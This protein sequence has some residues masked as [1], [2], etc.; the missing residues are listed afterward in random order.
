MPPNRN[1]IFLLDTNIFL[2]F[3]T[4]DHPQLSQKAKTFFKLAERGRYKIYL[5]ELVLGEIVWTLQSFYEYSRSEIYHSLNKLM[6]SKFIS[7]PRKKTLIKTLNRY[8][9]SSLSF[10]DCWVFEI[11]KSN[12]IKLQTF[13]K[14]LQKAI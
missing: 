14:D 3:I 1:N 6:A 12:K 4:N 9:N 2:R 10:S 11:A 13:D 5:D 7:N 8:S